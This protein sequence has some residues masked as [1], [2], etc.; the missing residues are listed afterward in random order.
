MI[1]MTGFG[2]AE[3]EVEGT[4]ISVEIKSLNTRYLDM[5]VSLPP[6]LSMLE[7]RVRDELRPLFIRGR[8]DVTIRSRDVEGQLSVRI[9]QNAASHWKNALESLAD[10]LGSDEKIDLTM[11][12]GQEGVLHNEKP[13]NIEKNW[14]LLQRLLSQAAEQVLTMRRREGNELLQDIKAQLLSIERS[15]KLISGRSPELIHSIEENLRRRFL[16]VLGND[17]DEQ[18]VLLETAS[19]IAKMNI[20]EEIVRLDFHLAAFREELAGEGAMGRKLDFLTQEMGREMNTIGSKSPDTVLSRE[21]VNMKD[22]LEK[23]KEQLR[24]VE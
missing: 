17:V 1:S 12:V 24:N 11:I 2:Y 21:V 19:W 4:L 16:E 13:R 3:G 8:V 18:R 9:D 22:A 14:N 10:F 15:L 7:G 5:L 20:N 6:T 23:V